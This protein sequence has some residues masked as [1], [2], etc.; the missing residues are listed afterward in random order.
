MAGQTQGETLSPTN[1]AEN[2]AAEVDSALPLPKWLM[3]VYYVFPVVLYIPDAFFNFFVYTDGSN[4]NVNNITA[5]QIPLVILW[6]FL[7]AGVVG[8]AWL[9]SVFAP[10]HWARGNKFQ[11]VMCWFG[12]VIATAVT[13][14]NSLSYRSEKFTS[15][16]T[17][18]WLGLGNNGFSVTMILVAVAPPFWGLFWAIVQP[19]ETRRSRAAEE[20]DFQAKIDRM[21]QEAE[22]KRVKAEANAQIRAAQIKGL[23]STARAAR[24]QLGAAMTNGEED[25]VV[26][27]TVSVTPEPGPS[28]GDRIVA[29][30]GGTVRR[31]SER[32]VAINS[33]ELTDSGEH[34]ILRESS[35]NMSYSVGAPSRDTVFAAP[36]AG[37]PSRPAQGT[38][39]VDGRASGEHETL[40]ATSRTGMPRASTLLRNYA[41]NEH[42]MRAVDADIEQMRV[43]GLRVTAKVFA[44]YRGI[45]LSQAQQLLRKWRDWKQAQAPN[46]RDNRLE[47]AE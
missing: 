9:L 41:E 27:G 38:L 8:M 11:S 1:D 14:W 29:L 26:E 2:R 25:Q 30:P 19:V 7:A 6:G 18:K 10:W 39:P 46:Q 45:E 22:L 13:I 24:A 40:L 4:I 15:F 16:N 47:A 31:L 5:D 20:S 12:V 21:K 35:A 33:G 17:D 3:R 42:V 32:R 44:E 34:E 37:A 36:E 43:R 23:A 28:T